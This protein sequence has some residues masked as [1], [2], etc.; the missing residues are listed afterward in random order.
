PRAPTRRRRTCSYAVVKVPVGK[1]ERCRACGLGS[2]ANGGPLVAMHEPKPVGH[3]RVAD[4]QV[5]AMGGE[6]LVVVGAA[7]DPDRRKVREIVAAT[8]GNGDQMMDLEAVMAGTAGDAAVPVAQFDCPFGLGADCTGGAA[9]DEGGAELVG[10][11][12]RDS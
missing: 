10:G 7:A 2:G 9:L 5:G 6:E 4:Q 1:F 8:P 12:R 3:I 11:D